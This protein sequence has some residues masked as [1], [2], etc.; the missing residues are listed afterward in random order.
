VNEYVEFVREILA[1]FGEICARRMFGGYG[2]YYQDLMFALIAD[3]ALYLKTDEQSVQWFRD[4]GLA[5]FEYVK[6]GKPMKLSY[7]AAPEEMF[8]NPDEAV[9]WAQRAVDA[10][11]RQ[12]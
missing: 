8:E 3:G 7:F 12:R 9:C 11:R 5:P 4:R 10:A 6:Q 2:L 1:P